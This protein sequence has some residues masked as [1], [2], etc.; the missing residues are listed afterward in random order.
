MAQ[1]IDKIELSR[2][3]R[4]I[5]EFSTF[6]NQFF[7]RKQPWT[8]KEKAKSCVY[9]GVNAV[10]TLAILLEPYIPF[11]AEKLWQQLNLEGSVHEQNWDSAS[12]LAIS[13]G[14]RINKPKV[15]FVKVQDEDI[16]RERE[17]LQKLSTD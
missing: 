6:C 2:G 3:L 16:K 8:D 9:L 11:S 7:Q 1:E 4:K 14:H 17:K 5:I 10:R 15:L 13:D 12:K